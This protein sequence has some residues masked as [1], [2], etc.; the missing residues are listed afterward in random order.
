[1]KEPG[2][3]HPAP[4]CPNP[5][6]IQFAGNESRHS[7]GKRNREAHV[8][9]IKNGRMNHHR[10]ILQR[11][12]QTVPIHGGKRHRRTTGPGNPNQVEGVGNEVVQKEEKRGHHRDR[13]DD[14]RHQGPVL[15]SIEQNRDQRVDT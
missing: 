2:N 9:R 3:H 11:W 15:L 14:I 8:T 6:F 1:M 4:G 7:K 10:P 5:F 13:H 12:I